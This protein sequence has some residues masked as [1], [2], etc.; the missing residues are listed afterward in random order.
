MVRL[1]IRLHAA[2]QR[3]L[4][5]PTRARLG[6]QLTDVFDQQLDEARLPGRA[7]GRRPADGA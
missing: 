4:P 3:L 6:A 1:A 2:A 5:A 7:L